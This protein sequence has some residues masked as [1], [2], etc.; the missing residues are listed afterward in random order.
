V[1]DEADDDLKGRLARWAMNLQG[2]KF[3]ISHRKGKEHVVPDAL[4]RMLN[5]ELAA[6]EN[7]GPE[8]DLESPSFDE[9]AYRVVKEKIGEDPEAYPD[10]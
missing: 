7:Y 6:I 1:A 3:N 5:D 9:E 2:H 10:Y 8:V 4:S